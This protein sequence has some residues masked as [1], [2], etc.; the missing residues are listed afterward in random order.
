MIEKGANNWNVGLEGACEGGNK[1]IIE[2]MIEKG[3]N[4]LN[5]GLQIACNGGNKEI[6]KIMKQK[7]G[8]NDEYHDGCK[9][10]C[11]DGSDLFKEIEEF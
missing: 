6:A 5:W 9:R 2:L 3:A 4:D 7:G 8:N 1:E 11:N 10:L